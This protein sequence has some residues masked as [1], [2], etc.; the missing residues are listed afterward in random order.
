MW[1]HEVKLTPL[2][3]GVFEDAEGSRY[4]VALET[5]FQDKSSDWQKLTK[6]Q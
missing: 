5:E 4:S 2:P 1:S 6:S 3:V